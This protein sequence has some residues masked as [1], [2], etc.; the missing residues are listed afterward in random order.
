MATMTQS[1]LSFVFDEVVT[2]VAMAEAFDAPLLGPSLFTMRPSTSRRERAAS[3]GELGYYA[4]KSEG[5]AAAED[6]ITQQFE[7]TVAH[8]EYSKTISFTRPTVDDEDWGFVV[9]AG[10]QLGSKGP[11]TVENEMA[12]LFI[13]IANSTFYTSEDGL[14]IANSA[15]LNVD[16]GNSQSNTGTN[17]LTHAGAKTTRTAMR[18]W[19]GY[20][21][22]QNLSIIPDE[23]IVPNDL[24]ED[25]FALVESTLVPGVANNDRNIFQGRYRVYVWTWL[26]D[27]NAWGMMDSR[28]RMRNLR[29]NLR[30][31][32]EITS[33]GSFSTHNREMNGYMR[34]SLMC[35]DW[36]WIYWNNPS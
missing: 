32:L 14:S 5:A 22:D 36:R 30:I 17:S 21:A 11:E 25:A 9:D 15:H 19:T 27:T 18:N 12:K 28:R 20:S 2:E 26:T 3:F 10:E 23:I 34:W 35:R 16:S 1:T 4:E 29:W 24:E 8:K 31:P 6:T 13:N 33:Q 7:K